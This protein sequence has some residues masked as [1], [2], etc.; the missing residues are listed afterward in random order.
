MKRTLIVILFGGCTVLIAFVVF[1]MKQNARLD[2]YNTQLEQDVMLENKVRIEEYSWQIKSA[3][4]YFQNDYTFDNGKKILEILAFA[5][6]LNNG[7]SFMSERVESVVSLVEKLRIDTTTMEIQLDKPYLL[8]RMFINEVRTPVYGVLGD[9]QWMFDPDE[10]EVVLIS[11]P[12]R[13]QKYVEGDTIKLYISLLHNFYLGTPLLELVD[14]LGITSINDMNGYLEEV[15]PKYKQGGNNIYEVKVSPMVRN[16]ISG[17][18]KDFGWY[19][20]IEYEVIEK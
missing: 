3:M 6:S 16:K 9:A 15:A 7:L 17:K 14:T 11:R 20:E 13:G 2:D 10:V 12:I 8:S 19:T 5:D 4:K 18:V 1:L